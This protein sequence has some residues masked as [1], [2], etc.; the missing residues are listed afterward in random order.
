MTMA[1]IIAATTKSMGKVLVSA[2]E[3]LAG[4]GTAGDGVGKVVGTA[5]E[6]GAGVSVGS[7][8]GSAMVGA[9]V[10]GDGMGAGVG[11]EAVLGFGVLTGFKM[12]CSGVCGI[13]GEGVET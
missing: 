3:E 13:F 2:P 11:I 9:G 4:I 10:T 6:A 5:V 8:E 1:T 7:A 12:D